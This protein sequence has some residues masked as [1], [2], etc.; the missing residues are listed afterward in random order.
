MEEMLR[1]GAV[2][3]IHGLRGEVKVYPTTDHAER[4]ESLE[5]VWIKNGSGQT[6]L[7]IDSVRYFKNLVIL[8]FEGCDTPEAAARLVHKDL[9]IEREDAQPLEENE[10]Y[11]GDLIGM[12]VVSDQGEELGILA[13]VLQMGANDVYVVKKGRDEL[14]LP[15]IH[16]CILE[17]DIISSIMKVHLMEG[18]R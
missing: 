8:H 18:L 6:E 10:Y 14:L 9:W 11:I 4:F 12:K 7:S 17:I 3:S 5:H 16:E 15:A 1:V 13:D 2:S